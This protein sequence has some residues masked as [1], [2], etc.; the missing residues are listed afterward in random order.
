MNGQG[1]IGCLLPGVARP[2][3]ARR[4]SGRAGVGGEGL[5]DGA[6]GGEAAGVEQ[7]AAGA[8]G[9]DGRGVV[10]DEQDRPAPPAGVADRPWT[11]DFRDRM[12]VVARTPR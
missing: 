4:P 3:V 12:A 9:G 11:P 10:A 8:A 2:G 6:V 5:G 7:Q 1:S